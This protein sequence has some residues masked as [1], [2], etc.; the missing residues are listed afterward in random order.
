MGQPARA[1]QSAAGK[2]QPGPARQA[3]GPSRLGLASQQ[4]HATWQG[5]PR[6]N[7]SAR[8][9]QPGQA[10]ARQTAGAGRV[11]MTGQPATASR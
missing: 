4:H 10:R 5:P 6:A 3:E 7:Q 9:S 1:S 8:A 11:T 2:G